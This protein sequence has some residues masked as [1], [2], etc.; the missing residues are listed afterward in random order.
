MTIERIHCVN[1]DKLYEVIS[2]GKRSNEFRHDAGNNLNHILNHVQVT[3]DISDINILEAFV[4]KLFTNTDSFVTMANL[5]DT[6]YRVGTDEKNIDAI[7]ELNILVNSID[8][9]RNYNNTMYFYPVGCYSKNISLN[10]TGNQLFTIFGNMPDIFFKTIFEFKEDSDFTE[11]IPDMKKLEN[12]MVSDFIINFY[13]FYNSY[14][15]NIDILVDSYIH[16]KYLSKV[17]NTDENV[18]L[19]DVFTPYGHIDFT[20]SIASEY[21][22][23]IKHAANVMY[24][25]DTGGMDNQYKNVQMYL[26]FNCNFC[27]FLEMFLALPN[28]L[29]LDFQD[30]KTLLPTDTSL[31]LPADLNEYRIRLS[32]KINNIVSLRN[33]LKNSKSPFD[34]YNSIMLNS[35]YSFTMKIS[36]DEITSIIY[37]YQKSIESIKN[38]Y[39]KNNILNLLKS[40]STYSKQIYQLLSKYTDIN[41][42]I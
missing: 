6:S 35:S 36:L 10:L 32:N 21:I 38:S 41:N 26:S 1:I 18:R 42:P 22:D 12:D 34:I 11:N 39:L 27:T 5:F 15:N 30:I 8:K 29:F 33:E 17:K 3:L 23:D 40:V 4:L 7:N 2:A 25:Y 16:T 28:R 13:K 14:I 19:T 20:D 37:K 24:M 9:D 31:L